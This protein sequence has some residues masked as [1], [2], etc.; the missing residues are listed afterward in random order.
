MESRRIIIVHGWDSSPSDAW[1]PWLGDEL[2]ARGFEVAIPAMPNPLAPVIGEWV[3]HLKGTVGAIRESDIFVGHSVGVQAILRYLE[4]IPERRIA[5][6]V[7]V[8]GWFVLQGLETEEERQIARPWLET[9][10]DLE[11]VRR[12]AG[13]T[14][15]I[16]SDDDPYVELAPTA[17]IFEER[18]GSRVII[19]HAMGHFSI[20]H[21]GVRELPI[22]L[23]SVLTLTN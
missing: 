1:L 23:D 13:H 10:I 2:V 14:I 8:A 21:G 17:Q 11:A 18:L 4:Q 6:V 22:A 20:E 19:E 12:V 9:P 5:G 16:L 3:A 15:A 7:C